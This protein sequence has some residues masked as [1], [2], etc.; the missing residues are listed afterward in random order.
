MI[1]R[2][3]TKRQ[4]NGTT[5][6]EFAFVCVVFFMFL[7]GILEYARYIYAQNLLNNAAREG[8]RYAVVHTTTATTTQVQ[9]YVD[10]YLANAGGTA[11]NGYAKYTN[12]SVFQADTT[13]GQ[14]N[15]KGWQNA[16]AGQAIGVTISGTYKALLPSFLFMNATLSIQ[17]TAIMYSETN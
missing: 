6:T 8:A 3:P 2:R 16:G 14:D 7:F 9:D 5:I 4:C 13:T 12:I 11:I 17:G 15:S 10:S 1:K